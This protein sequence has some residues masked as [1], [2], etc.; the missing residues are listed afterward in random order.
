[1]RICLT[2]RFSM[3]VWLGEPLFMFY[4]DAYLP[5]IVLERWRIGRWR[6]G[7]RPRLRDWEALRL[8]GTL[9]GKWRSSLLIRTR[10]RARVPAYLL[11]SGT[12]RRGVCQITG[13]TSSSV[14]TCVPR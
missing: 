1:M 13:V 5:L 3:I 10:L 2:S 11:V 9:R 4:N 14:V 6:I 7:G 12:A 8:R